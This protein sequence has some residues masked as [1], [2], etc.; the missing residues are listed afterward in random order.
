MQQSTGDIAQF[1]KGSDIKRGWLKLTDEEASEYLTLGPVERI[2]RYMEKYPF[3]LC[4]QCGT[5]LSSHS[6]RAFMECGNEEMQREL[7][8]RVVGNLNDLNQAPKPEAQKIDEAQ[9]QSR[10][11]QECKLGRVK[12]DGGSHNG[13][14]IE[15]QGSLAP[16]L[17][18]INPT[19]KVIEVYEL[20]KGETEVEPLED[21]LAVYT[22]KE[23]QP[24]PQ[25]SP[26]ERIVRG[27]EA[28][29]I[30]DGDIVVFKCMPEMTQE[31]A[32][33]LNQLIVEHCTQLG[34]RI[35]VLMLP[36]GM[37][38]TTISAEQMKRLGWRRDAPLILPANRI[39]L[40]PL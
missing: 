14:I 15:F 18:Y 17:Q 35:S 16:F 19:D 12:V 39:P 40:K 21:A 1:P 2:A 26:A 34:L 25:A 5:R 4:G 29:S 11:D 9:Q 6:V 20:T 8:A 38:I 37:E 3:Q 13:R 7:A 23:T 28:I 31:H 10:V 32:A 36:V 27:L 24:M 30:N 33:A 22:F